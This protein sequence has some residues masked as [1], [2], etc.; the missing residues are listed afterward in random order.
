[1]LWWRLFAF[2]RHFLFKF[3]R[4]WYCIGKIGRSFNTH[5]DI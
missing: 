2:Y 5:T 1:L 3:S 4:Y